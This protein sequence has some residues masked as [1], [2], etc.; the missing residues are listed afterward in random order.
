VITWAKPT[1][2][3]SYGDFNQQTEFCLYAWLK[4]GPH[5]WFGPTNETNL[6]EIDREKTANL[7]HPTQKS[8][9]IPLRAIRNSSIRGDVVADLFLGSGVTLIASESL[10]RRCFGIEIEP[11]YVDAIVKRYIAFVGKENV[12]PKIVKKYKGENHEKA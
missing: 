3:I 11:K 4:N 12:S 7:I 2:A 5:K 9:E 1:F 8:V 10:G 6:W